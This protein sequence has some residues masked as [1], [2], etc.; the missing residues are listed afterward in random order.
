MWFWSF[1]GALLAIIVL[2]GVFTT[3][4]FVEKHVPSII[5]SFGGSAVLVFGIIDS[6]FAQPRP[7]VGGHL[8]AAIIG[9]GITKLFER[10]GNINQYIWLSGAL[11]ISAMIIVMQITGTKHPPAGST[12][13][14]A[15]VNTDIRNLGWYYVAVVMLSA[16]LM[17]G[18][19]CITNNLQ[20]IYPVFWFYYTDKMGMPNEMP[21]IMDDSIKHDKEQLPV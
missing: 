15:A 14:L 16:S 8:F 10:T 5:A 20:R 3:P 7:L 9:V 11:A 18:V 13:L 4:F 17:L 12:A 1:I 6:P 21:E 19:A 2:Q